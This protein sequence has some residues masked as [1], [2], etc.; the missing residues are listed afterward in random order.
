MNRRTNIAAHGA[1]PDVQG[2]HDSRRIAIENVG[3]RGLRIPISVGRTDQPPLHTVAD[4]E[5]SVGLPHD[6]KGTHMSRFVEIL[7]TREAEIS[8]K[9]FRSMLREMAER[10]EA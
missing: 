5:M 1:M 9:S 4:V 2:Q 10:L 6:Q 8:V 3:I 7:S